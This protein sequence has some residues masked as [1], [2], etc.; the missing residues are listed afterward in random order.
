M[1]FSGLGHVAVSGCGKPVTHKRA[2]LT[3]GADQRRG[4]AGLVEQVAD[5]PEVVH[6]LLAQQRVHV[7]G[8]QAGPA[9]FTV[10]HLAPGNQDPGRM[11]NDA[12]HPAVPPGERDEAVRDQ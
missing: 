6:A 2:G 1:P 4:A 12:G 9:K 5:L 10:L 8:R 7:R 3:V 11:V